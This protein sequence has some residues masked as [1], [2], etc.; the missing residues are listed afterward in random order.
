[1]FYVS[2]L[3]SLR[4]KLCKDVCTLTIDCRNVDFDIKIFQSFV[5]FFHLFK[6]NLLPMRLHKTDAF[7]T[8]LLFLTFRFKLLGIWKFDRQP[9]LQTLEHA[10]AF[11]G[12]GVV[13]LPL[14]SLWPLGVVLHLV[15]S[16]DVFDHTL[17][18]V[19]NNALYESALSYTSKDKLIY[20]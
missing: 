8:A 14:W 3:S 1:M 9:L 4:I 5:F 2:H 15:S 20:Y 6:L 12:R 17:Q 19:K 16:M 7:N 11:E 10:D 18:N 13:H